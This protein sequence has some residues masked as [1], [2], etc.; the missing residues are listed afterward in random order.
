MRNLLFAVWVLAVSTYTAVP[1]P[2]KSVSSADNLTVD[3]KVLEEIKQ[4]NEILANLEYLSDMIG[5]R[6]TGTDN[7]DK[8]SHWTKGKFEQYGLTNVHLEPWT[9][10]HAWYRGSAQARIV[11][12]A[13]HHL[14]IA[15]AGWS[16]STNGL[17]HGSVLFVSARSE[18]ELNAYRG[19]LNNK[20]VI[21]SAPGAVEG[22][23]EEPPQPE[24]QPYIPFF[25]NEPDRSRPGAMTFKFLEDEMRFFKD[26]GVTAVLRD[27]DKPGG[28]MNMTGVGGETF[29]IGPVPTAMTTHEDYLLI[30][31]L[32]R[33]GPVEM[34]IELKNAFSEHPVTV[35]NTVAELPGVNRDEAVILGAHL[36]SWDLAEGTTDNGTGSMIVLEAARALKALGIQPKRTI[37][38]VLFSGEEAGRVAGSRAYVTAH[39]A[40]LDHIDALG[41]LYEAR[42]GLCLCP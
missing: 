28:L 35:Y 31:R 5:P 14:T 21:S 15:A 10:Q 9:I 20:I 40:E 25:A 8:A 16:P 22:L 37:R 33:R 41:S 30:W 29:E 19:K 32:L 42:L 1:K 6:L 2:Q 11:S 23:F 18:A 27:S 4:R 36:D 3:K 13:V 24:T 12:P 39:K 7:M 26:Q 38:F 34:E 17:V